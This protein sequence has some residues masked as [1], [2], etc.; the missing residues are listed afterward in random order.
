MFTLGN[1][2]CPENLEL[3]FFYVMFLLI[4]CLTTVF[5]LTGWY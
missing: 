3:A 5:Y 4:Q 2:F 1:S